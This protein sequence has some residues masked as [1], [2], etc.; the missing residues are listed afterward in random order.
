MKFEIGVRYKGGLSNEI[1]IL[2]CA[3]NITYIIVA[4]LLPS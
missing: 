3:R 4:M 2:G 1:S